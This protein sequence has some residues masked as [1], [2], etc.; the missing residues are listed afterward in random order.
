M[1]DISY[2]VEEYNRERGKNRRG[3]WL[4]SRR[5]VLAT[6]RTIHNLGCFNAPERAADAAIMDDNGLLTIN[7]RITRNSLLIIRIVLCT[8]ASKEFTEHIKDVM[9]DYCNKYHSAVYQ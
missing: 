9:N 7:N 2:I 3:K 6:G 8:C 1:C 4:K 5:C